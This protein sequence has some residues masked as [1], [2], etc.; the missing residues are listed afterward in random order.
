MRGGRSLDA[1]DAFA[2]KWRAA[3][4]AGVAFVAICVDDA[5]QRCARDARTKWPHLAHLWVDSPAVAAARVAFVPN[6]AVLDCGR[7]VAKWWDG[8]HGN[9]LRGPHGASRK[10]GSQSLP[11]AIARALEGR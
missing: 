6:R 7:R 11:R 2:A 3:G 9:V 1:L 4:R 5:P 10:N 8:S